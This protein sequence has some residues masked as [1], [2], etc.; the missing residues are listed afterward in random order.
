MAT[1]PILTEAERDL[2]AARAELAGRRDQIAQEYAERL[3]ALD[4]LESDM[5]AGA[6]D[7][8]TAQAQIRRILSNDRQ[9]AAAPRTAGR[10]RI[11]MNRPMP[12]A[13]QPS[14]SGVPMAPRVTP[15]RTQMAVAKILASLDRRIV[16]ILSA[17]RGDLREEARFELSLLLQ[18][19][20]TLEA[21]LEDLPNDVVLLA[22]VTEYT[23]HA[24]EALDDLEAGGEG[25][26]RRLLDHERALV[27]ELVA[28]GGAVAGIK[29]QIRKARE[30]VQ[31]GTKLAAALREAL[32]AFAKLQA[33]LERRFP[34]RDP[35]LLEEVLRSP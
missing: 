30:M 20:R 4:Q 26:L 13:R 35:S 21:H 10:T 3:A 19:R 29:D 6:V 8:R 2:T 17:A 16:Q 31:D 9:P 15:A 28:L 1:D 18:L 25:R 33:E 14:G 34:I 5:R 22:S 23:D 11:G 12:M 27:S 24:Q 32:Q 7:A